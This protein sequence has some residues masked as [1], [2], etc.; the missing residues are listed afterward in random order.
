MGAVGGKLL[1]YYYTLGH[2]AMYVLCVSMCFM[3]FPCVIYGFGHERARHKS[4]GRE[5]TAKLH[6]IVA[7]SLWD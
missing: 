7:R 6:G 4:S 5:T 2:L 3:R 1:T